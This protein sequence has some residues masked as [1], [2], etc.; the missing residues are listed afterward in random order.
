MSK[1]RGG[2]PTPKNIPTRLVVIPEVEKLPSGDRV[3]FDVWYEEHT[4]F[5]HTITVLPFSNTGQMN[6]D[7]L[8]RRLD[9]C[10]DDLD[11]IHDIDNL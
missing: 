11:Y 6:R 9:Q 5:R 2:L 10:L 8:H 4:G 1:A 3:T 7:A